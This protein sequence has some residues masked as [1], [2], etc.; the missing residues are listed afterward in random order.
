MSIATDG[1]GTLYK[2]TTESGSGSS[3]YYGSG[4]D[5]EGNVNGGGFPCVRPYEYISLLLDGWCSLTTASG[6]AMYVDISATDT[7]TCTNMVICVAGS[8]GGGASGATAGQGGLGGG[9]GYDGDDG[10]D[11]TTG[12]G[13]GVTAQS[14]VSLSRTPEIPSGGDGGASNSD[15]GGVVGGD[16]GS[17]QILISY[18]R[19]FQQLQASLRSAPGGG[20]GA[21]GAGD[22]E[23]RG[24]GSGG[25]GGA[26]GIIVFR[27]P[28]IILDTC[29]MDVQGGVGGRGG[30]APD[31]GDC[32]GGG[33]G[34]GGSGGAVLFICETLTGFELG[35]IEYNGG[36]GNS[37]GNPTGAGA[38]GSSGN[39]GNQG[40]VWH[41]IPSTNTWID[42]TD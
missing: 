14:K 30:D 33:G 20:A 36:S 10:K 37:G 26:G 35:N 15:P 22:G 41:Y 12:G 13:E 17:I 28:T 42:L 8:S 24:G 3:V 38:A 7:L 9:G 29:S 2:T 40:Q 6:G 25:G 21:A 23:N 18:L 32:G 1:F 5:G 4:L 27:A 39:S 34:A 16:D 19:Q 11:G 31:A